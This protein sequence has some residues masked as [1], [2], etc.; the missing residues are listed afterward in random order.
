MLW[1]A[2]GA[3]QAQAPAAADS[4]RRPTQDLGDLVR[5]VLPPR[6]A[7][8]APDSGRV[9]PPRAVAVVVLPAVGYT[10]EAR[11]LASVTASITFRRPGANVSVFSNT[12]TYTQNRQLVL[13]VNGA[14]WRPA[15]RSLWLSDHRL[16]HYPQLT[17]GLGSATRTAGAVA[18]DYNLLRLHQSYYHRVGPAG[19]LY[20]GVGY[21]L[22]QRWNITSQGPDG[23]PLA[24]IAGYR[25][26]V[27]GRST[28]SGVV[29]SVLRDTRANPLRPAAGESY[30]IVVARANLR[31]LA[32]DASYGG[33]QFDTR[34][35]LP[36]GR[37]GNVLAFWLY[38]EF[39]A[40]S[41]PYLDLPATG[42]DT[43]S[44]TGRGYIQGR[45]RGP[46]LLYGEAEYRFN[47]TR[48]RVL[49][50]AVFANAQTV[51]APATGFQR[52]APAGGA[53][54]RLC[55]SKKVGTFLAVDYAVGVQGSRG[56][57]FNLGEV[58]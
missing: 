18:M 35:Y 39:V 31:A 21:F 57:F 36:A 2:G 17:Y 19:A 47:L 55:L 43:H 48:S 46:G 51:R 50:G 29:A 22:D 11:L 27:A 30:L 25:R 33:V 58:F 15:N 13:S 28:S 10:L 1:L 34:R 4:V 40:S 20:A 6:P 23:Q 3:A 16:L 8:P 24:E 45:F 14:V 44:V 32:S 54:L 12:L 5:R 56:V 38:G 37:P 7:R 42:W 49:G 9:R 26:G 41:A 52:V 53:G